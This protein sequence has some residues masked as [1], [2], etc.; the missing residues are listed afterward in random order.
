MPPSPVSLKELTE[1]ELA[2]ALVELPEWQ[3]VASALPKIPTRQRYELYR[4]FEFAS[5]EDAMLFMAQATPFI[6]QLDHH[7]RW[8]NLW[9]T[10]S[11]W[12]STWD[13]GHQP[14][15]LDFELARYLDNLYKAFVAAAS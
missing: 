4:A 3:V 10:V 6:T 11:V 14:S 1:A 9:C 7:P 5:F 2:A 12:L 8:E 15:L 13:I